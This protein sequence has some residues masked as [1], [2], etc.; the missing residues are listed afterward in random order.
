MFI[1]R[2]LFL[3]SAFKLLCSAVPRRYSGDFG[4]G[5]A[6]RRRQDEAAGRGG[7]TEAVRLGDADVTRPP[8]LH[9]CLAQKVREP[10]GGKTNIQIIFYL[11]I[12]LVYGIYWNFTIFAVNY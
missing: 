2:I 10:D 11:F 9:F 4:A 7:G 5:N 3:F 1:G 12:L 8:I 6:R